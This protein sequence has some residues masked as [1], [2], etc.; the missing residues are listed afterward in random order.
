MRAGHMSI[1]LLLNRVPESFANRRESFV[2]LLIRKFGL[3]CPKIHKLAPRIGQAHWWWLGRED[4]DLLMI[5][6]L[7][8]AV[9]QEYLY[10]TPIATQPFYMRLTAIMP[11]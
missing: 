4:R 11:I 8:D 1:A 7:M 3:T 9:I 5:L 2:D 6:G 10:S